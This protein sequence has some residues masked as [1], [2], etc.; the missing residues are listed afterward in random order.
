MRHT[1]CDDFDTALLSHVG[2]IRHIG[3]R[4]LAERDALDDFTQEVLTRSYAHR[5]RLGDPDKL[6]KWLAAIA[7]NTATDW[8]RKQRPTPVAELSEIAARFTPGSLVEDSERWTALL[9]ALRSLDPTDQDIVYRRYFHDESYE[10]LGERH[11]LSPE[12]KGFRLHRSRGLLRRRLEGLL[13]A[14]GFTLGIRARGAF[15]GG[16]AL[17]MGHRTTLGIAAAVAIV[18][19]GVAGTILLADRRRALPP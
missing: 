11:G 13:A 5:A 3:R 19:F 7:R 18:T 4:R 8:N 14:I 16:I 15:I 17:K 9:H 6:S 12:A 1:E 10:R 2:L